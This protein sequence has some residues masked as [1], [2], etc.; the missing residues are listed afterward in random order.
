MQRGC[1]GGATADAGEGRATGHANAAGEATTGRPA[2]SGS[3]GFCMGP[4]RRSVVLSSAPSFLCGEPRADPVDT[5][6]VFQTTVNWNGT[7]GPSSQTLM[8]T[9]HHRS[10]HWDSRRPLCHSLYGAGKGNA[11]LNGLARAVGG[12]SGLRCVT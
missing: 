8:R 3:T 2:P 7:G 4:P 10:A 1:D 11:E 5:V 6:A 9:A 12:G